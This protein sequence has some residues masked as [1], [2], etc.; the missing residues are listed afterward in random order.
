MRYTAAGTQTGVWGPIGSS[1][2]GVAVNGVGTIAYYVLSASRGVIRA[3]DLIND[4]SLGTFTTGATGFSSDHNA[5]LAVSDG[6]VVGW[7]KGSTPGYLTHYSP[8]GAVL[9]TYPLSGTNPAPIV[10]T[11][12]L[13][14]ST[15]WVGYYLTADLTTFSQ[16]TIEERVL[17]SGAV[18]HRF[19]PD[20]GSFEFD[21]SFAVLGV[22][23]TVITTAG[24]CG[25]EVRSAATCLAEVDPPFDAPSL[26]SC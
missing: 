18:L 12:G 17:G 7:Q 13:T 21:S 5:L 2:V 9:H 23:G 6:V 3:W 19:S 14:S 24:A 22:P 4:L 26:C 25:V 8:A 1:P 16:V 10:L 20:D 15:I 11:P